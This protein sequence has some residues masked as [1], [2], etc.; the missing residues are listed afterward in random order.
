M[1]SGDEYDLSV[2]KMLGSGSSR[3]AV[4]LTGPL[5]Y[6]SQA[7]GSNIPVFKVLGP[8]GLDNESMGWIMDPILKLVKHFCLVVSP[9]T[10]GVQCSAVRYSKRHPNTKR[11]CKDRLKIK[12]TGLS[13]DLFLFKHITAMGV[14]NIK[15]C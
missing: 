14:D 2:V 10:W 15:H 6:I 1:V 3:P 5:H 12:K 13:I 11:T 7:I 9:D 8:L 4:Q